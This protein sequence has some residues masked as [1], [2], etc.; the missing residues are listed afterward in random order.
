MQGDR[1]CRLCRQE[2][3]YPFNGGYKY[4]DECRP[5]AVKRLKEYYKSL[6]YKDV[7]TKTDDGE[8]W[9]RE[10]MHEWACPLCGM[11]H[12]EEGLAAS[13]CRP[14]V[15]EPYE[16]LYVEGGYVHWTGENIRVKTEEDVSTL[17]QLAEEYSPQQLLAVLV[18]GSSESTPSS[19]RDLKSF[20]KPWARN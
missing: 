15:L 13:C 6:S 10:Y 1:V 12:R 16:P 2:Y 9:A 5:E 4:C 19:S 17:S 8:R 11:K 7:S 18:A 3:T 20:M 14:L